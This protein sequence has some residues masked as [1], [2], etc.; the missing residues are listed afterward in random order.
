MSHL[1]S[2]ASAH[3]RLKATIAGKFNDFEVSSEKLSGL[4]KPQAAATP[5]ARHHQLLPD[6][7]DSRWQNVR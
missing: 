5:A 3:A 1:L 6:R 2:S 7:A 4:L